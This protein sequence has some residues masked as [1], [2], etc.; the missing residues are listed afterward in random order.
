M[1][2]CKTLGREEDRSRAWGMRS[3]GLSHLQALSPDLAETSSHHSPRGETIL[4][5]CEAF[6]RYSRDHQLWSIW[7][8]NGRGREVLHPRSHLRGRG[9]IA[10]ISSGKGCWNTTR[11]LP[12]LPPGDPAAPPHSQETLSRTVVSRVTWA[13]WS[14]TRQVRLE[15]WSWGLGVRVSSGEWRVSG[16]ILSRAFPAQENRRGC[17]PAQATDRLQ[18]SFV[19]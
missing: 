5:T 11:L 8:E 9:F 4:P 1:H 10:P 2:G 3:E 15:P 6:L 19:G 18:V 17:H 7:E 16:S 12:T 14:V 13:P